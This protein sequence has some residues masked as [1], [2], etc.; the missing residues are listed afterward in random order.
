MRGFGA[1]IEPSPPGS[2]PPERVFVVVGPALVSLQSQ[3]ETRQ[4]GGRN[5]WLPMGV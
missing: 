1:M 3:K 5:T 2:L 4:G